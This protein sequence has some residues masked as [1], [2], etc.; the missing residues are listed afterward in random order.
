MDYHKLGHFVLEQF[1][2]SITL[3]E[4]RILGD[5]D[6]KPTENDAQHAAVEDPAIA[7]NM[8]SELEKEKA[9]LVRAVEALMKAEV[10]A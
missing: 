2:R 6:F 4:V 8:I 5:P 10:P 9:E 1:G 7:M 3:L